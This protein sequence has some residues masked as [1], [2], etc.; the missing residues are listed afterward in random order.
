MAVIPFRVR[1]GLAPA[2]LETLVDFAREVG[3]SI[4][5]GVTEEGWPYAV[6][7]AG[8]CY[9]FAPGEA[10]WVI[11]RERS[12]IVAYDEEDGV[13]LTFK[14]VADALTAFKRL[15]PAERAQA[16]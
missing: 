15:L 4:E 9:D 7:D 6:L 12:R 3:S 2:E 16:G 10:V 8:P 5:T 14:D 11:S 1:D 13:L